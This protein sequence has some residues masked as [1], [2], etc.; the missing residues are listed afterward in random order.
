V[1][2][3]ARSAVQARFNALLRHVDVEVLERAFR[4]QKRQASAA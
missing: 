3:S 2:A 4:P 1:N